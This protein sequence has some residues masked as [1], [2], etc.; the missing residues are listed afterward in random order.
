MSAPALVTL[1]D[2][3]Q[4]GQPVPGLLLV[5]EFIGVFVIATIITIAKAKNHRKPVKLGIALGGITGFLAVLLTI[6]LL[7]GIR[8]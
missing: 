3:T 2:M 5:A 6:L 8:M 4:K 7:S 1:A